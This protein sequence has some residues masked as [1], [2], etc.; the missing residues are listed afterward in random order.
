M[1]D[2]HRVSRVY[3]VAAGQFHD[4]DRARLELLKLLADEPK[5]RVKV[6]A[7]Y[8]DLESI[9]A[10]D[11]LIT[12]TCNVVP[13]EDEQRA[14]RDFVASGKKW[15]ALHGTNSILKFLQ[16][17]KVDA[18]EIAPILMETLGTQF[19]GHPPIQKF[20]VKVSDPN[21]ELV[22]GIGE[23]ETDDEI[24]LSRIHGKLQMLLHTNFTGAATGF[25]HED[26]PNDDPRPIYY[27]NRVGAGEV[28]Y[29][30]LGHC[31]GH[32]D[33]QDIGVPF[34]PKIENG[35]WDKPEYYELLRRGIHYCCTATAA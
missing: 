22:R 13:S 9:R 5:V 28:L 15:F 30:N 29:L 23:F 18:P 14:L 31:R 35:S 32:Y 7:D 19:L 10:S 20:K 26:W 11:V 24:Y 3:L 27:I 34:Y 25:V 17:G 12:Y 8:H 2:E 6:A 1:A 21:H 4:I 33:M 16:S